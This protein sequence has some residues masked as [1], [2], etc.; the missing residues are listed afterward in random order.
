MLFAA[1]C[2]DNGLISLEATDYRAISRSIVLT[3]GPSFRVNQLW[4]KRWLDFRYHQW[5]G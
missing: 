5:K 2:P 3:Y 1:R 4:N